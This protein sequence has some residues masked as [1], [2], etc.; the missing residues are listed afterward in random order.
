VS[1]NPVLPFPGNFN[2]IIMHKS[3]IKTGLETLDTDIDWTQTLD[4]VVKEFSPALYQI[5][6]I[7]FTESD[8]S[9]PIDLVS[10]GNVSLSLFNQKYRDFDS[11]ETDTSTILSFNDSFSESISDSGFSSDNNLNNYNILDLANSSLNGISSDSTFGSDVR[12]LGNSL[13][14]VSDTIQ[15]PMFLTLYFI[16]KVGGSGGPSFR[17]PEQTTQ[18]EDTSPSNS[19]TTSNGSA[20]GGMNRTQTN[21]GNSVLPFDSVY[22]SGEN[23]SSFYSSGGGVISESG[24][25]PNSDVFF[26]DKV[27]L[28]V[29]GSSANIVEH[30]KF[31]DTLSLTI[32]EKVF[33]Y[34][35]D[36]T[37]PN[38]PVFTGYVNSFSRELEPGGQRIVYECKDLVYYL[39]QF[40][41]PSFFVYRP[42]V[43][44]S[45]T[46]KTY[47][48]ILK[49]LCNSA[50][51]PDSII[52]L[53]TVTCPPVDWVYE[54][55]DS[56][57][58][59]ATKIFGK[60]VYYIDRNG[61]LNVRA[62]DSG[63]V[64]KS[65]RVPT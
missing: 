54:P 48:E 19:I 10:S 34:I 46:I 59:W 15:I 53:P 55:M 3:T 22:L 45:G 64:V 33:I 14:T 23:Y 61:R 12:A 25:F 30:V 17:D 20:G 24:I 49:E 2:R 42:P 8:G 31:D 27:R 52:D 38:Q 13:G 40:Y 51:I 56:I 5:G 28:S 29:E 44:Q 4:P 26:V 9:N 39:D 11:E 57:L 65:F 62:V 18:D 1:G 58:E 35:L 43:N 60:Y 6:A 7:E 32:G 63:S 37:N 47:S 36:S 41:T 50:G 21:Y 16:E